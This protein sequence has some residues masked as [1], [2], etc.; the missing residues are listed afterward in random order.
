MSH[1]DASNEQL[2][3][4]EIEIDFATMKRA[5]SLEEDDAL[6][7]PEKLVDEASTFVVVL[8]CVEA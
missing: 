7:A 4:M 5:R 1:R 8:F 2:N 3:S 6:V